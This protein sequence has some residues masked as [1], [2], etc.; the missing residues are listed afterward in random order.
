MAQQRDVA[1]IEPMEHIELIKPVSQELA[2]LMPD[3]SEPGLRAINAHKMW[4]LG[5]TGEGVI[6]GGVDTGV[7][8]TH[9]ALSGNWHGNSV[10]AYK[11][12]HDPVY[13]TTFPTDTEGHGTHTTGT[14]AGLDPNTSDTIGAAF[15]A[16]WIHGRSVPGYGE[17]FLANLQWMLDP[18]GNPNTTNDRPD[19]V[20]CSWGDV[21]GSCYSSYIPAIQNLEAAGVAVIFAAGNTGPAASTIMAPA[22]SN[23]TDL[24]VFSVGALDGNYD[25]LL[26]AAFSSRGPTTCINGS[27]NDIKP[28][29]SAPGLNVRSSWIGETYFYG[30]GT[31]MATPH[32][33]GAIA[34]LKQAFP[35]K[36][37]NQ[38]KKMLYETARDLGEP[39]EDNT[40]GMGII[41]VYQAYIENA[42]PENPRPPDQV[43]AYSDYTTPSSVAL[44][45]TDPTK[46]VGG[47]QLQNFEIMIYRDSTLIANVA[48]GIG[49]YTDTALT[50]GQQYEYMV[51]THHITT[52]SMSI[53]RKISAWA[54]GSP[55]PACPE[56]LSGT[57]DNPGISLSWSDP[58]TQS[59]GTPLDDLARIYIYRDQVLL[60]SV[61]AGVE[62]YTDN[63]QLYEQTFSYSLVAGDTATP[64]NCSQHSSET[65]IFA[66]TKPDI[67]VYYG[68]AFGPVLDYVDSV[69]QAIRSFNI[70][71]YRTRNLG[72]FGVPLDYDA[73][74]VITGM[75]ISYGHLL[76]LLDGYYLSSY[77]SN[78]GSIYMEGNVCFNGNN[79]MAG[80]YNIRP[81]L[82]LDLGTWTYDPVYYLTGLNEFSGF[83]FNYSGVGHTWDILEPLTTTST[84]WKDFW[85]QN[86]YGVY[87]EYNS[88]KIIG[89]VL[90]YGGMASPAEPENKILLMCQ[91]LEMLGV[92]FM[93]IYEGVQEEVGGQQSAVSAYPNP[94]SGIVDFRWSIVDGRWGS[95]KVYNAQ[96][97]E[98]ATVLDGKWPGDQVVRW[99]ASNLP[100]GIYYYR[101]QTAN[102]ELL[103]GKIVKY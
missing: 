15:G 13:G 67:L 93:C 36:T 76:T 16:E 2:P 6:V 102:C 62:T 54:G 40:Y 55:F 99:D 44:T 47:G 79:V 1:Q 33:S 74:F 96:G 20:N 31:S 88:G 56:N 42:V 83:N 48:S 58:V 52:D 9:P 24:Q 101:L 5:F 59:D 57:Y 8:G 78:G 49:Q 41:D 77:L 7:E 91:Y 21:P 53:E 28:E 63:E 97:Q 61:D 90:P 23:F 81:W 18:D 43:T 39:G 94:T 95:L 64:A 11:A 27:A 73:V 17:T 45:W 100:A 89:A 69:Y 86:I 87:N 35:D 92:D 85:T 30:A 50:D 82:G 70:P 80:G 25:D 29:V 46:L 84:L 38:L 60:D 51:R 12:W 3:H 71:V 34:L 32:V 65:E 72:E 10:P 14:M 103:T 19:V 98:V 26:I 4:Q 66:G 75:F 37:G 68:T 22:K